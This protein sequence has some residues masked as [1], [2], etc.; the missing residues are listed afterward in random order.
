MLK[1]GQNIFAVSTSLNDCQNIILL[2][3]NQKHT[4]LIQSFGF[5]ALT[6]LVNMVSHL[7]T[8]GQI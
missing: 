4:G 8:F 1:T 2:I 5:T 6:Q 3:Y 7:V